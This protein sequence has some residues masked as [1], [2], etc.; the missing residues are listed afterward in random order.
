MAVILAFDVVALSIAR[1]SAMGKPGASADSAN[2]ALGRFASTEVASHAVYHRM[3]DCHAAPI[4]SSLQTREG[5][6]PFA[7]GRWDARQR[8]ATTL[9]S[10]K[11]TARQ[12]ILNFLRQEPKLC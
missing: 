2:V 6:N 11:P 3:G 10:G 8:P 1:V 5:S 4:F 12:I 7:T 9:Q